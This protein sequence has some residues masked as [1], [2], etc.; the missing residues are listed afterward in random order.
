MK[1]ARPHHRVAKCAY[2]RVSE[3][4]ESAKCQGMAVR[5]AVGGLLVRGEA[6]PE[7]HRR[8]GRLAR[9][10]GSGGGGGGGMVAWAA[11]LTV[12]WQAAHVERP[13]AVGC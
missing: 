6:K 1:T 5:V 7:S 13:T 8:C 12:A 9:G 4:N 2:E 10:A 11:A 3:L